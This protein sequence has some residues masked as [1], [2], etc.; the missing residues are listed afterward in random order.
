[1]VDLGEDGVV[2]RDGQLLAEHQNVSD[3]GTLAA[4]A[5]AI[6][7]RV[8]DCASRRPRAAGDGGPDTERERTPGCPGVA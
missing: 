8:A 6:N 2:S 1:M 7:Y 4:S 3:H 5:R